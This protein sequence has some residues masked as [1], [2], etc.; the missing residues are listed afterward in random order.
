MPARVEYPK[1]VPEGLQKSI[2]LFARWRNIFQKTALVQ[3]A[4]AKE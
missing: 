2:N 1:T 4:S 3:H